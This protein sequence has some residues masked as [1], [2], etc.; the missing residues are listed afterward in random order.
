MKITAFLRFFA[1]F[2]VLAASGSGFSQNVN[3]KL[4]TSINVPNIMGDVYSFKYDSKT[5]GWVYNAY[6]TSAQTSVLVTPKGTSKPYNMIMQYFS[7]FDSEGNSYTVVSENASDTTSNYFVLKNNEQ[8]SPAYR[9]INEGWS[10]KNGIIYF[11]ASEAD[12]SY[13]VSYN[14]KT[15]EFTNSKPYDEVRLVYIPVYYAEGEPMGE[16]GFTKSGEPYF[17]GVDAAGARLVIGTAEQKVYSDIMYW[18]VKFDSN[19]EPVYIAKDQGKFYQ[20]RGNTFVVHGTKEFK[21]FD[22]VYGP[23]ILDNQNNAVYVGQD[24]TGEYI[25]RSALMR[26]NEVLKTTDGSFYSYMMTP[27]GKLAY[28]ETVNGTNPNDPNSGYSMVVVD[29]KAGKQYSSIGMLKFSPS[30]SPLYTVTDKKNKSFLISGTEQAAGKY[31]YFADFGYT[32]NGKLFYIGTNYGNYE[33][34]KP[35]K[36][37]VNVDGEEFGPYDFVYTSDYKTNTIVQSDAKGNFAFVAGK[38][39]DYDNYVYKYKVITNN[40]ESKDFDAIN[41]MRLLNGKVYFFGGTDTKRGSYIYTY[42]LYA[43]NKAISGDYGSVS[44]VNITDGGVYT[45]LAAKDKGMYMVEVK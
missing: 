14:T 24:S 1:V 45:F 19:G 36:N 43:N 44:E 4:I 39:T 20:E 29:G 30:S 18:D 37:I 34:K 27:N 2:A 35:D 10:M 26:E 28:I 15:G 12:K 11:S 13:L 8:V 41:E 38:N 42:K 40:W 32:A 5:G 33:T 9:F 21:K 23:V 22:Y 17:V 3:E 25:Y 7:L 6:D 16:V 31:D